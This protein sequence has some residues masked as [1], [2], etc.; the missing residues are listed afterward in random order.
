[1][2]GVP[3][4]CTRASCTVYAQWTLVSNDT[5]EFELEGTT[6]GWVAIGVSADQVMGTDGI[7]DVFVCQR[8][9]MNNIVYAEDTYNPVSPR[10]NRRDSVS[11][12][13]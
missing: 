13:I 4:G 10:G 7:D 12:M 11:V 8:D 2:F 9:A 6:V 5:L 3:A 1:M